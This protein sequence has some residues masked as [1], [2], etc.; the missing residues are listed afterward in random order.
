M[1]RF[2]TIVYNRVKSSE[3]DKG[4]PTYPPCCMQLVETSICEMGE[5]LLDAIV[6][7]LACHDPRVHGPHKYVIKL[8]LPLLWYYDFIPFLYCHTIITSFKAS[9]FYNAQC[10][11]KFINTTF[12]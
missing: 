10:K 12:I 5:S 2:Q 9:G 8:L 3:Q 7:Y 6:T 11:F 1:T 4:F